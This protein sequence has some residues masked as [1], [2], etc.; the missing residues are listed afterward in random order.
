[1]ERTNFWE[2]VNIIDILDTTFSRSIFSPVVQP[3]LQASNNILGIGLYNIHNSLL[4]D[5]L[6][7][8]KLP[9]IPKSLI[10]KKNI[11]PTSRLSN[12]IWR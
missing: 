4:P 7:T 1:M 6:V 5:T 8:I 12:S 2:Y 10:T 9:Y 3:N 11:E